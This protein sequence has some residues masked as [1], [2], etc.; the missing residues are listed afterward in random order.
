MTT[1]ANTEVEPEYREV[2]GGKYSVEEHLAAQVEQTHP[3]TG[4]P[5]H[6][7]AIEAGKHSDSDDGVS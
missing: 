3:G 5:L 7:D 1:K 6:P 4:K 2:K